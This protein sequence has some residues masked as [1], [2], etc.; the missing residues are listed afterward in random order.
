MEAPVLL[1]NPQGLGIRAIGFVFKW[2]SG[3]H[4]EKWRQRV[5]ADCPGATLPGN[6]ISAVVEKT[7]LRRV[8]KSTAEGR[9]REMRMCTWYDGVKPA[10]ESIFDNSQVPGFAPAFLP[11]SSAPRLRDKEM[12]T[13]G[14]PSLAH[15]HLPT[16]LQTRGWKSRSLDPEWLGTTGLNALEV[17]G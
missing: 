3:Q 16:S 5:R 17:D 13:R 15:R 4:P 9:F 12:E 2:L 8:T 10:P 1:H 11:G 14:A 7:D 6:Q